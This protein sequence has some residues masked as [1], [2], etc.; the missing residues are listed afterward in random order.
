MSNEWADA[1]AENLAWLRQLTPEQRE[2]IA[3][4]PR[5]GEVSVET[6]VAEW[7]YHDLD[8]LRQIL[9]VLAT[10][11]YANIGPFQVLY[12]PPRLA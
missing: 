5:F 11:L 8:H 10:E 6:Y 3:K 7:A 4:H 12:E 1:R 2:R 9:S